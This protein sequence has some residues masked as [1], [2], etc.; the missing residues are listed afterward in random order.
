[1][2]DSSDANDLDRLRE[3]VRQRNA[4]VI[5][6]RAEAV[7]LHSELRYHRIGLI[8]SMAC[9]SIKIMSEDAAAR[10]Q[11]HQAVALLRRI[12]RLDPPRPEGEVP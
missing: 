10:D 4:N 5:A 6:L 7:I 2:T 9:V 1:M 3:E 12:D 11:W 8:M